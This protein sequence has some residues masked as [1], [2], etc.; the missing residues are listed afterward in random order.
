MIIEGEPVRITGR[1][2]VDRVTV[3]IGEGCEICI[4]AYDAIQFALV[5]LNVASTV[6]QEHLGAVTTPPSRRTRAQRVM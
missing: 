6:Y 4:P 3:T 2:D 1:P 5:L